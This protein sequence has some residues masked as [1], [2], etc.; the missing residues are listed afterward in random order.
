[1]KNGE[2]NPVEKQ[3]KKNRQK[4]QNHRRREEIVQQLTQ[5]GISNERAQVLYTSGVSV[6][7]LLGLQNLMPK[8]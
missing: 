7:L 2:E 5:G 8:G 3:K 6:A 4:S 1:M